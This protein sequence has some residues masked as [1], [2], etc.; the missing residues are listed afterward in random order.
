L[1]RSFDKL[2]CLADESTDEA[3]LRFMQ[4]ARDGIPDT[5]WAN[6]AAHTEKIIIE[7]A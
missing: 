5:H 1:K 6:Y 2:I 3:T 7:H 4:I